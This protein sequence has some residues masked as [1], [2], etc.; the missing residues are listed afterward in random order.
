MIEF[1]WLELV[2]VL[3]LRRRPNFSLQMGFEL[4]LLELLL[5]AR[6]GLRHRFSN[7]TAMMP[8]TRATPRGTATARASVL[9]DAPL[10]PCPY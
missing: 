8:I 9:L 7:N 4:E 6:F 2:L 5:R 3:P 1:P 10:P